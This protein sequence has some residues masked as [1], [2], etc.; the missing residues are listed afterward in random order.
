V[1]VL[2]VEELHPDLLQ[3]TL[4]NLREACRE[5]AILPESC[6]A[7]R[8]F[9][10]LTTEPCAASKYAEIWKGRIGPGEGSDR[11]M[12]VC[13]KVIKPEK[14]HSVGGSSH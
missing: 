12:D 9:S 3:R 7:P 2:C 6:T 11:T 5:R 1:Q 4:S 8:G 14:V 13:A 10:K